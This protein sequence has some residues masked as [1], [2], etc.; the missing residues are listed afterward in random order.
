MQWNQWKFFWKLLF[1]WKRRILDDSKRISFNAILKIL[2]NSIWEMVLEWFWKVVEEEEIKDPI[3]EQ[4]IGS[5][6]FH[7]FQSGMRNFNHKINFSNIF[8]EIDLNKLLMWFSCSSYQ[9]WLTAIV[10][11]NKSNFSHFFVDIVFNFK[12]IHYSQDCES[13]K[14][15]SIYI[16]KIYTSNWK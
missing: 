14:T 13:F 16:F 8:V 15:K 10:W 1:C 2:I 11:L 3:W 5:L 4:K 12:V 9:N 7:W 6:G